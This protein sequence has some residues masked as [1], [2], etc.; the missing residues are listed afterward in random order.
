MKQKL[1]IQL[2]AVFLLTVFSLNIIVGFACFLGIDM[3][4]N[5]PLHHDEEKGISAHSHKND[6]KH[7]HNNADNTHHKASEA[8][9]KKHHHQLEVNKDKLKNKK[10][11]D[12]NDCCNDE[13]TKLSQTDNVIVQQNVFISPVFFTA[14]ISL[15]YN[16]DSI[17]PS[18]AYINKKYFVRG[19][20]PP[21][22]NIRIAIQSFQI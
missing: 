13:V 18:Q 3:G 8:G 10:V 12:P 11:A 5:T 4:F 14:L 17:I 16:I 1:S 19:H 2:K 22:N 9:N 6:H 7:S 15:F 21:I 20:H